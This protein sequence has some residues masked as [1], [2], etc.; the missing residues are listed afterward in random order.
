MVFGLLFRFPQSSFVNWNDFFRFFIKLF[1][2]FL[3]AA[4]PFVG[5]HIPHFLS[6]YASSQSEVFINA[7]KITY[8]P[9]SGDLWCCPLIFFV[10]FSWQTQNMIFSWWIYIST[11][12][13]SHVHTHNIPWGEIIMKKKSNNNIF[14]KCVKGDHKYSVWCMDVLYNVYEWKQVLL[15]I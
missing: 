13:K 12:K 8:R 11:I 4:Q 1:G 9:I 7:R 2:P 15:H 10:S 6:R 14:S 5:I 3:G